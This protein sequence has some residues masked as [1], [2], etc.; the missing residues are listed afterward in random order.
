MDGKK[1]SILVLVTEQEK[2]ALKA[3]A[4]EYHLNLSRYLIMIGLRGRVE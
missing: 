3:R 1:K 2:E 4:K